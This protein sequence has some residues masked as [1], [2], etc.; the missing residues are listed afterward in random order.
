[1]LK[2]TTTTT[3]EEAHLRFNDNSRN[4][5]ETRCAQCPGKISMSDSVRTAHRARALAPHV[6]HTHTHKRKR[7]KN[8]WIF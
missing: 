7:I 8:E 5:G 3:S 6:K 2:T 1:M 4:L